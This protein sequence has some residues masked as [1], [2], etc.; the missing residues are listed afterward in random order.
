GRSS[1]L[2]FFPPWSDGGREALWSALRGG[3]GPVHTLP[4]F[5][6]DRFCALTAARRVTAWGLP[7]VLAE[8]LL[9]SGRPEH[10]DLASLTRVVLSGGRAPLP[11][12]SRLAATLPGADVLSVG[13]VAGAAAVRTPF[14]YDR[15]RPGSIGRPCGGGQVRVTDELGRELP[16]GETGRVWLAPPQG[17]EERWLPTAEAGFVD[18]GFVY[19]VAARSEVVR[20]RGSTVSTAEVA[21]PRS[22]EGDEI[23]EVVVAV[24]ER[25]LGRAGIGPDDNFFE[26]GG[27]QAAALHVLHLLEDAFEVRL[28][29]ATFLESPTPAGLAA[30][31]EERREAAG[32]S[33][34]PVAPVA[35]SQEGMLWQEQ[36]APGC[37]N[38]PP[39]ARRYRGPLDVAALEWALGEIVRRHEP[40]RTRFEVRDGRPVQVVSDPGEPTL[41][42]RDLSDLD[43]GGQEAEVAAV[44]SDAARPF[45][46]VRGPMFEPTLLVLGPD[47]HV[48]VMRVHHSVYDDWSVSVFRRELSAFYAAFYAAFSAGR[49]LLPTELP[50]GFTG[51]S[52]AQRRR[53]AGRAGTDEMAYWRRQ[54]AGAPVVLQLPVDDPDLPAGAPQP[55]PEPVSVDLP[56]AVATELRALARRERATLFMTVLTAFQV[57]LHRYTG[58]PEL[59]LASVVANR[60]RT[61]LEEMIGCFTKKVLLRLRWTGDETFPQLLA[62]AR[63]VVLGAVSHQDLAFETVLQEVLGP[64]AARHGL[65]PHVAVM[66]QGVTPQAEEVVLPGVA[67]TGFETSAT[68]RRAHFMAG[69]E[70]DAED[71]TLPWGGG[72]YLGSFLILS[73]VE[74]GD[75]ISLVARGAFHRPAVE[76]LLA[77]FE[78][79][80]AD[81][82]A[83]PSRPV[84][85]LSLGGDEDEEEPGGVEAQE[86]QPCAHRLFEDQAGRSPSAAAV[87]APGEVLTYTELDARAGALAQGLGGMGVGPGAVVGVCLPPSPECVVAVLA[88]WKA[89]AAY[90]GLDREDSDEHLDSVLG[91]ASVE[92]VLAPPGLRRPVV[93]RRARL[94]AVGAQGP[95][96][97]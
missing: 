24:W 3:S 10:H 86:V 95:V 67:T 92:V 8:L 64:P 12:V 66:F 52:R 81:L 9:D 84:S 75:R 96:P 1:L 4:T 70:G 41:A 39:L 61:E 16:A 73:V 48:L 83:E 62:R 27:D 35:F 76:R 6:A 90:L 13:T 21:S 63:E 94:V 57:L 89:G 40:L 5:D 53:L 46:L 17:Q 14:R 54:L 26:L 77:A 68:T 97:A 91:D 33:P 88:V 22:E 79:L 72:L 45:D 11:L 42:V 18:D 47:D 65:V 51:F 74:A 87:V 44:L 71:V 34:S 49:G 23:R 43:A 56:P 69:E 2:H 55:S 31:V 19:L 50:L 59:V 20:V 29:M 80:L 37:Q 85:G 15:S 36:F 38:L 58:Q 25:V 30:A 78:A 32:A 60:N 93:E 7:S 82:V 28:S